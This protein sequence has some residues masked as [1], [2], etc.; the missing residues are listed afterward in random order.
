MLLFSLT[1]VADG[2]LP[3]P[4][5]S[6]TDALAEAGLV[7]R[8]AELRVLF[9]LARGGQDEQ[10]LRAIDALANRSEWPLPAREALLHSF[11]L[12]LADLDPGSAGPLTMQYLSQYRSRTL[13]P[14]E[15]QPALG[16]PLYNVRAAAAGVRS[17]WERRLAAEE[18]VRLSDRGSPAWL[19]GYLKASAS[20]R[21]GF[22]WSRLVQ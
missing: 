15:D 9:D 18:A 17:E 2:S 8:N 19:E 5:W 10:L 22:E 3:G 14:L 13:V 11:T 21:R 4:N 6:R 1:G 20:Q 12:G 7:H 16:V